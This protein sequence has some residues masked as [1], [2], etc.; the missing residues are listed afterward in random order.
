[1]E[2]T[3]EVAEVVCE[4]EGMWGAGWSAT[5]IVYIF[6]QLG[7]VGIGGMLLVAGCWLLLLVRWLG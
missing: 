1:M 7:W 4:S 3:R 5:G 6:A 2:R